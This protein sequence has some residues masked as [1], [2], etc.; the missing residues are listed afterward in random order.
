M[1]RTFDAVPAQVEQMR[2]VWVERG[3][4]ID[5]LTRD[6]FDAMESRDDIAVLRIPEVVPADANLGCSVAGGYRPTPPTLVVT[7]SMSLRRQHFTLLHELGHHLQRT[8]LDLGT[9]VIE[10]PSGESFEDSACDSFAAGVLIPD[11][12]LEAELARTGLSATAAV[13]LF[14]TTNASRAAVSVRL[15]GKLTNAG[16]VA[17]LDPE[18]TVTFAAS[19]GGLF[20]PA[21]TSNQSENPLFTAALEQR[22]QQRSVQRNDSRIH[23]RNGNTSNLLYGHAA[24][25]GDRIFVVM[26]EY[27]A[28][29]LSMSPPRESTAT[30]ATERWETCDQCGTSFEI[31]VTCR[32][33]GRPQCPKRHCGCPSNSERTCHECFI[34]KPVARFPGDGVVCLDCRSA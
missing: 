10:H 12:V 19:R 31:K 7:A 20:P 28:S 21:R 13:G 2:R 23:Y 29:W 25:A 26:V 9:K 11:A 14:N 27:G 17:V 34:V 6:A 24:W 22:E 4:T 3:G 15:A 8:D 32:T 16:V 18:G 1:P 33:C 5:A 30:F